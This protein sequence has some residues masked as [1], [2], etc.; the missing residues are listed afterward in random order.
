M[1]LE[2]LAI[3]W[4]RIVAERLGELRDEVV[5]LGGASIG[6]LITDPAT[7]TVR[8]TKDVD[9]IVEVGSWSEYA[10]LQ[11]RLREK[12]FTEDTS[13]HAP[14]CRWEIAGIKVDV[15]PTTEKILGFSNR[16]YGPAMKT[17]QRV[18]LTDTL[19]INIAS[20]PYFVATKIEA[21]HGRGGGDYVISHDIEDLVAVVDG[22]PEINREIE[23]APD[24]LRIFLHD[25]L[26]DLLADDDFREA[27][28]GHLRGDAAN[29]A[30]LPTLLYRLHRIHSDDGEQ[31]LL[32]TLLDHIIDNQ[33]V[34]QVQK[35]RLAHEQRRPL[36]GELVYRGTMAMDRG[37]YALT[38][39]GLCMCMPGRAS[40]EVA[41]C[42]IIIDELKG[43]YRSDQE[44]LWPMSELARRVG[45][46]TTDTARAVTFL[47]ANPLFRGI[48]WSANSGFIESFTLGEIVLDAEH[49]SPKNPRVG[50]TA[51]SARINRSLS[52][53]PKKPKPPG[54]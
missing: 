2:S 36:L 42:N 45:E 51:S 16:W 19:T 52:V 40:G 15:M 10:P 41:R 47:S 28:R 8:G 34:P 9:V 24:D 53:K 30:R 50:G 44:R 23:Q 1:T 49:L 4:V 25:Q 54:T 3:E 22:R 20:P 48:N 38:A 31:A 46:T 18:H 11:E 32:R 12:G 5:F 33:E 39:D 6:L 13:E 27:L 26:A 43:M 21:F 37:R 29:Q 35:F 14:L 7:T 17:A